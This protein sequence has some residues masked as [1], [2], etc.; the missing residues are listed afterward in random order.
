MCR[1]PAECNARCNAPLHEDA[2]RCGCLVRLE[3]KQSLCL[4]CR[5]AHHK[6]G[7]IKSFEPFHI[8]PRPR[9]ARRACACATAADLRRLLGLNPPA[10]IRGGGAAGAC[11]AAVRR[12]CGA[13]RYGV[14]ARVWPRLRALSAAWVAQV[15]ARVRAVP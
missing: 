6:M 5:P 14:R 3:G 10:G 1:V 8:H 12:R 7:M 4:H 13:V 9:R 2:P 11:G 15:C